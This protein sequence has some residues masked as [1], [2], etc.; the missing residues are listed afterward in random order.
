MPNLRLLPWTTI[1]LAALTCTPTATRAACDPL[2]AI[3]SS[4]GLVATDRV[5]FYGDSLTAG[6]ARDEH[7][8]SN[9][10]RAIAQGTYCE[11]SELGVTAKGRR[12]SHYARYDR[13]AARVMREAEFPY[14]IIVYQ[15]AGKPLRL[16]DT[17]NPDSSRLFGNA[18]RMTVAATRLE[19]PSSRIVLATTPRLDTAPA[20]RKFERLYERQND[21]IDHNQSL[22]QIAGEEAVELLPWEEDSCHAWPID[23]GTPWTLDGV[24]PDSAGNLALALATLKHF[25]IPREDLN[26]DALP[27]LSPPLPEASAALVADLIYGAPLE[28]QP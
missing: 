22:C 24:H 2:L 16:E 20:W 17:R 5:L 25:G 15:D 6:A 18:V 12:G 27:A 3:P 14:T 4:S 21:W 19:S 11:F 13:L 8:Y 28:C 26:F 1:I 23:A 10:F 7:H 9:L